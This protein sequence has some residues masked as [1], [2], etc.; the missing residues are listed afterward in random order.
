MTYVN[1]NGIR[2]DRVVAN[3][4]PHMQ[5][6]VYKKD[7]DKHILVDGREGTGKSKLARQLAKALDPT[8]TIDRIAYNATEFMIMVKSP[9]R[10]KGQAI[11]LDEAYMAINSRAAMSDINRAMV[12]LATEM[13][14]LNLFIIIV[15][16]TFFDL[17]RY[18]AIWR[19]ETLFHL[20]FDDGGDRGQYVVFPF[21]DKLQLYMRGKKFYDYN[22]W[23]SPYPPC[24]FPRDDPVDEIEYNKRKLEAFRKRPLTLMERKWKERAM[25][26]INFLHKQGM[27]LDKIAQILHM[28]ERNVKVSL[29]NWVNQ[30][31]KDKEILFKLSNP[32][33]E[34][35][36]E[37]DNDE[38]SPET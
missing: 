26:A 9:E 25:L 10:K 8:F 14:Q 29:E 23:H 36:E 2:I 4:I 6:Q 3:Q 30:V 7:R 20:Y 17:D 32:E 37:E 33:T 34:D 24:I 15:L 38:N 18:F 19:C 16:P 27:L 22:C 28:K 35:E 21:D 12:G 13:R 31:Q 1:I 5:E 11:I